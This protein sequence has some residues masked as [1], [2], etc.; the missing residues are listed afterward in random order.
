MAKKSSKSKKSAGYG[1]GGMV[2]ITEPKKTSNKVTPAQKKRAKGA[3]R[4]G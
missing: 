2:S 4:T 3:A 1:P